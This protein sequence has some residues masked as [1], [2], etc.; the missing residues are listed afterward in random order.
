MRENNLT[1][2]VLFLLLLGLNAING[3]AKE[4][5]GTIVLPPRTGDPSGTG[6]ITTAVYSLHTNTNVAV[7]R[8]MGIDRRVTPEIWD[9]LTMYLVKSAKIVFEDEGLRPAPDL[10]QF[11]LKRMKRI[12]TED[13][14]T[15]ELNSLFPEKI[16]QYYFPYL[17]QDLIKQG[18]VKG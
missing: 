11:S 5:E 6:Q 10:T 8:I 7:D 13:G 18:K 3:L 2:V 16:I 14:E 9:L 17:W 15:I 12:I 4:V 1:T